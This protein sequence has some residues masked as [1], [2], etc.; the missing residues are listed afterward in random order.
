MKDNTA[1]TNPLPHGS[2]TR[3]RRLRRSDAM[4]SMVRETSLDKHDFIYPIFIEEN[5]TEPCPVASMP[6]IMRHTE[7]SLEKAIREAADTGIQAVLLFGVSHNK[8]ATGS[9]SLKENGLLSR[10]I[11]RAKDTCPD[12]LVIADLCFCEYTDHGHC[13]PIDKNGDVNNDATLS[14][15]QKQAVTAVRAGADIVAPSGMMDGMVS[16]IRKG[17]DDNGFTDTPIMSYSSKFASSFYGPFR[18]AAGCSLGKGNRKTYQLDPANIRQAL[19]EAKTDEA[20]GAD[21]LMV[22]PGMPYLD[23]LARLRALT[24][25]PLAAYQVSGEYAMIKFA[26]Q[27]GALDETS[28]MMES[29]LAFKRAGADMIISYFA[30]K[31]AKELG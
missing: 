10:M 24:D 25:L 5:I 26:S 4:R 2:F 7:K 14:N 29:L 27:S 6:G 1:C 12:M 15:L 9:D 22:K 30:L 3:L 13:G 16:A 23:V 21:I 17:L 19:R 28:V 11:K 31:A 18:D 20:E 8:D